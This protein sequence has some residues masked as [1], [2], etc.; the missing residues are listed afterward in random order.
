MAISMLRLKVNRSAI[1]FRQEI[2][3]ESNRVI[4]FEWSRS[5]IILKL[6]RPIKV[7]IER[8]YAIIVLIVSHSMLNSAIFMVGIVKKNCS[9]MAAASRV[10]ILFI[11]FSLMV[12]C[13]FLLSPG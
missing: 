6:I 9:A 7:I 13:A 10:S 12:R 4:F 1:V 8:Q 3:I 2:I 5:F 11:R